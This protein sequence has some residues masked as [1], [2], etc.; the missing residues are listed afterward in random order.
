MFTFLGYVAG[1]SLFAFAVP[2]FGWSVPF[3]A[4]GVQIIVMGI[5]QTIILIRLG[6]GR[7]TVS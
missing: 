1:P 2:A 4:V 3:V 5:L 7:S 6:R